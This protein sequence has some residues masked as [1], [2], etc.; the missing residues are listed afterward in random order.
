MITRLLVANRGEIASRVF[1]TCRR[2]GI[3]AVAVHSPADAGLPF[4]AEAD[5]AVRLPGDPPSESYLR[6]DALLEAARATGAD[7]VDAWQQL[8]GDVQLLILS[9]MAARHI[10]AL[11]GQRPRVLTAVMP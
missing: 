4:V 9:P 5:Y 2:L 8:D 10:E 3:E 11:L 7:A 6:I 1:A